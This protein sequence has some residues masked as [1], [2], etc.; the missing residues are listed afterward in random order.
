MPVDKTLNEAVYLSSSSTLID[1]S[2]FIT[3]VIA[4]KC[5]FNPHEDLGYSKYTVGSSN[6]LTF[7]TAELL[8]SFSACPFFFS[9]L[10][11]RFD[12]LVYVKA[13][14][15]ASTVS[16]TNFPCSLENVISSSGS[17]MKGESGFIIL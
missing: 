7:K 2:C 5:S 15:G 14:L 10:K 3:S 4:F 8:F 13:F 16:Y 12:L 11:V 9:S 1:T 6:C 17:S